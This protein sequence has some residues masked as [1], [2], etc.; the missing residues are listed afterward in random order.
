MAVCNSAENISLT[1]ERYTGK[2]VSMYSVHDGKLEG[3]TGK[4]G[5]TQSVQ[6][7]QKET[8]CHCWCTCAFKV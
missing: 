5:Q 8:T 4:Y 2:N 3:K 6:K 1:E 7:P